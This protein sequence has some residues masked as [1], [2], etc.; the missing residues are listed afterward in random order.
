VKAP[1]CFR[2]YARK[3]N[4]SNANPPEKPPKQATDWK[5][6]QAKR[7]RPTPAH[8]RT[9][10][11]FARSK[12]YPHQPSVVQAGGHP[13]KKIGKKSFPID[14]HAQNGLAI[15]F[16]SLGKIIQPSFVKGQ[17]LME[18]KRPII[19]FIGA[20]ITGTALSVRFAQKGYPVI[21]VSSRSYH[22]G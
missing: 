12:R 15:S 17:N 4:I 22:S 9:A 8:E 14:N 16:Y 10:A 6:Y 13:K 11:P 2:G 21:A 7:Q 1:S 5:R 3:C 19:G 20:G 18:K